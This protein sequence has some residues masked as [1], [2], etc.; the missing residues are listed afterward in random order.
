MTQYDTLH[1][2]YPKDLPIYQ[3]VTHTTLHYLD[4]LLTMLQS[5]SLLGM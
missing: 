2:G 4:I 1:L 5:M 3:K